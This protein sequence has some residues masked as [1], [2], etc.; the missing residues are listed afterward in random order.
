MLFKDDPVRQNLLGNEKPIRAGPEFGQ[1]EPVSNHVLVS[2]F[3]QAEVISKEVM[4]S[5]FNQVQGVFLIDLKRFYCL[6][7]YLF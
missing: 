6:L 1:P 5:V 2:K 3:R 4:M 7:T